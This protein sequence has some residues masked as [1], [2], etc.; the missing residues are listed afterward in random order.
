MGVT[1]NIQTQLNNINEVKVGN[2]FLQLK[3]L[4]YLIKMVLMMKKN[5]I[6]YLAPI[7]SET[8]KID[9]WYLN[10]DSSL[11]SSSEN[12]VTNSIVTKCYK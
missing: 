11:S 10:I 1:S 2:I 5:H 4:N 3:H 12:L 7:N 6:A 8:G 9:N